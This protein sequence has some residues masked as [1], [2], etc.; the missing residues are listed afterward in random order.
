MMSFLIG[1]EVLLSEKKGLEEFDA[2]LNAEKIG[3]LFASLL[4]T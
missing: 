3:N 1:N 4:Q 2:K